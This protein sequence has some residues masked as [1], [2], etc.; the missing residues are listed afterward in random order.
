MQRQELVWC[1]VDGERL[2]LSLLGSPLTTKPSAF[3]APSLP[4]PSREE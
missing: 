1:V 4:P 2:V 3:A